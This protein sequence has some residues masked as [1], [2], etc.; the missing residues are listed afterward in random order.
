MNL[1]NN[2]YFKFF[3]LTL[4]VITFGVFNIGTSFAKEA[5][6]KS[7]TVKNKKNTDLIIKMVETSGVA[8]ANEAFVLK[9]EDIADEN[10]TLSI[11][12]SKFSE[13]KQLL[14]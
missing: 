2:T 5:N 7:T 13:A 4:L 3:I 6:T 10:K 12:N 1:R 8:A 14:Q 11:I 9:E